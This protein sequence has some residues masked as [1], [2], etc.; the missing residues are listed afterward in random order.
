MANKKQLFAPDFTGGFVQDAKNCG[1]LTITGIVDGQIDPSLT[2]MVVNPE[3]DSI[4]DSIKDMFAEKDPAP[5]I[6]IAPGI[7]NVVEENIQ[8]FN[9][10][11]S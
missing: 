8:E 2:Q 7:E 5:N 10:D 3:S 1:Q 9:P 6:A 11:C 4:L